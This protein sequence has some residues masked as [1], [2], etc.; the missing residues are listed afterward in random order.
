MWIA[1]CH[2][3]G[4]VEMPAP[5]IN[6]ILGVVHISHTLHTVYGN[7]TQPS[8]RRAAREIFSLRMCEIG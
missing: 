2:G 6:T 1:A 3:C 8:P 4:A 7:G 5:S